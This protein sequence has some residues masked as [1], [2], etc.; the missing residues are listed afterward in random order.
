VIDSEWYWRIFEGDATFGDVP[1]RAAARDFLYPLAGL[2]KGRFTID[3]ITVDG[4]GDGVQFR[5]A[6]HPIAIRC[7]GLRVERFVEAI[8]RGF[9]EA[10]LE[11]AF[12]IVESRR[13]ELRG[14]L[15]PRGA[16]PGRSVMRTTRP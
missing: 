2:A 12:A 6:G 10:K 15:V 1:G 16:A 7:R 5:A 9:A 4:D 14:V 11:L 3:Q 13:Y 8:N